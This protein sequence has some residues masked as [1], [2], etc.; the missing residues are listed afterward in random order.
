[1]NTLKND[2]IKGALYAFAIGDAMGATTE[3]LTSEQ[4]RLK[5]NKVTSL[6]GGGWLNLK[7]GQVT[8]DTQM[9]ICVINA[10]M[11]SAHHIEDLTYIDE[12][13]FV[14]HCKNNFIEWANSN[15]PDI[16]GRCRYSI[17][18]LTQGIEVPV[19]DNALGNGSLMR[20]L[21]CALINND[22]LNILQG[23]LTH[24]NRI[25]S[26]YIQN[27]SEIIFNNINNK[28]NEIPKS[29]LKKPSG[30]ILNT[31]NN[32]ITH[33]QNAFNDSNG[34]EKSIIEAVNNGDDAD[35]IAAIT[36]ALVGSYFGFSSIPQEWVKVLD[37]NVK[38]T[39]DKFVAFLSIYSSLTQYSK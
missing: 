30:H 26:K 29:F 5:Y 16:G 23:K 24:N 28:P 12:K 7:P 32:A 9:M 10:I 38:K 8:D 27:F 19:S 20:A 13:E 18:L 11:N 36:G 1:M 37:E 25:C 2:R 14:E 34:L 17:E 21:P 22:K 33:Y 4:I 6:I 31:Y 35:T 39:L 15:P 3:F